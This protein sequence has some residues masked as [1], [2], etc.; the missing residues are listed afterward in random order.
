MTEG[1]R[2]LRV[3][4]GPDDKIDSRS[5]E[6]VDKAFGI[7]PDRSW[8]SHEAPIEGFL[9]LR[10]PS[11]V[12]K[13]FP[14]HKLITFA[15]VPEEDRGFYDDRPYTEER[16][17]WYPPLTTLDWRKNNVRLRIR[18]IRMIERAYNVKMKHFKNIDEYPRITIADMAKYIDEEMLKQFNSL[19]NERE[20]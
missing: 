6:I 14:G 20:P 4:F 2:K 8:T 7:P 16:R 11:I 5:L 15:E 18:A 3:E 13:R 19:R 1:E 17:V 12:I 10:D 9:I